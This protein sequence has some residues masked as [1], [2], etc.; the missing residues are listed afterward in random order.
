MIST[1]PYGV[2]RH[3]MYSGVILF[4][5]GLVLAL[6]SLMALIPTFFSGIII[7]VRSIFEEKMLITKLSG[8]PEYCE[9]VK[10]KFI[11]KLL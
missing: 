9:K 3:P 1:G 11:P 8:Y 10:F 7:Y 5:M 4:A 6:G 2:V